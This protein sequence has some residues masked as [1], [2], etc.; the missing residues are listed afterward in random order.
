[1]PRRYAVDNANSATNPDQQG[2]PALRP[3]PALNIDLAWE[4]YIG[5][6]DMVSVSA[7]HK[8]IH[9]LTLPYLFERGGIW[10]S[11]RDNQGSATVHG[12]NFEGKTRRGP[13]ALRSNLARNWSRVDS[14]PGPSNHINGQAPWSGNLGVDYAASSSI[15]L[16]GTATWRT[17]VSSR[18]SAQLFSEEGAARQLDV[19]GVWKR[20][21]TARVRVSVSNLLHRDGREELLYDNGD[22]QER[23]TFFRTHAVW[24]VM[25]EQTL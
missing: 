23:T 24:R 4:R 14:V 8:R 13:L 12:I 2:N 20:D 18:T 3:E 16:G 6:D 5:K 25:W 15:D 21:R 9:D 10:T 7:F 17:R 22:R 19:Y 1:M 11:M